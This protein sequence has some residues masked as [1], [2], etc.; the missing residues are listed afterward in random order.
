VIRLVLLVCVCFLSYA[1]V[2]NT[3]KVLRKGDTSIAGNISI[4]TSPS[5]LMLNIMGGYGLGDG[6]DLSARLGLFA[7]ETYFGMDIEYVMMN[8]SKSD[9]SLSGGF[10]TFGSF[11]LD[12]TAMYS[13]ELNS[14]S[15]VF[16]GF[17]SDI[18]FGSFG[19]FNPWI[20]VGMDYMFRNNMIFMVEGDIPLKSGLSTRINLGI[21]YFL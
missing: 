13:Y 19:A 6:A 14:K 1:Q 12:A 15:D 7:G 2:F 9:F 8:S 10:H 3:G 11:G 4:H 16:V 17:D 5:D 21:H 18:E 20:A